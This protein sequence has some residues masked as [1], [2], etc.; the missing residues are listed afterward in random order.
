MNPAM[1]RSLLRPETV[2]SLYILHSITKSPI[3]RDIAWYIA[4]AIHVTCSQEY[5]YTA[6]AFHTLNHAY[7][8]KDVLRE[9]NDKNLQ[10]FDK[11]DQTDDDDDDKMAGKNEQTTGKNK[12]DDDYCHYHPHGFYSY[13]PEYLLETTIKLIDQQD[14]WFIAETLKYLYLIFT[15]DDDDDNDGNASRIEHKNEKKIGMSDFKA[16]NLLDNWVFTTEAHLLRQR[17]HLPFILP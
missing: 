11:S 2:E 8:D 12:L 17:A 1:F 16:N 4:Q 5:G 7:V 6:V 13:R 10:C 15:D 3:Y 14:S 9:Q